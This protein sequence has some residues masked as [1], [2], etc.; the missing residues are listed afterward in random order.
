MGWNF[1]VRGRK[2]YYIIYNHFPSTNDHSNTTN[3]CTVI[4]QSSVKVLL[5]PTTSRDRFSPPL[6]AEG[7]R[8][9]QQ[10][11]TTVKD[12][13]RA[14]LTVFCTALVLILLWWKWSNMRAKWH[15]NRNLFNHC[16]LAVTNHR[17][18]IN[19]LCL[20]HFSTN[21]HLSKMLKI[22]SLNQRNTIKW[23]IPHHQVSFYQNTWCKTCS[24]EGDSSGCRVMAMITTTAIRQ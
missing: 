7:R 19:N 4:I 6:M 3:F 15:P 8:W 18:H 12:C 24:Y 21:K 9:W 20:E 16:L 10:S 17:G 13:H 5:D 1:G 23:C 14:V 22:I 11:V 2:G